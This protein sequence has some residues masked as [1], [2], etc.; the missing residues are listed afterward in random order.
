MVRKGPFSRI[1]I[2]TLILKL[3]EV[4]IQVI[5]IVLGTQLKDVLEE[6]FNLQLIT[7]GKG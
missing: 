6:P 4:L 3:K 5:E 1:S 7:G 2:S